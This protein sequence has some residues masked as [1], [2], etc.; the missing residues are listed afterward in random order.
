MIIIL[1]KPI[2][3]TKNVGP[4]C[5][6]DKK[7]IE[8]GQDIVMTGW[9][10]SNSF[11]NV[12]IKN[13]IVKPPFLYFLPS[14]KDEGRK[15]LLE[16]FKSIVR[17]FN[18]MIDD[19]FKVLDADETKKS[20]S[21]S[22]FKRMLK[23]MNIEL[24]DRIYLIKAYPSFLDWLLK[25]ADT[26][27]K[28]FENQTSFDKLDEALQK[29]IGIY[30]TSGPLLKEAKAKKVDSSICRHYGRDTSSKLCMLPVRGV[31]EGYTCQG[32][33][34]GPAAALID[35]QYVVVAITSSGFSPTPISCQCNCRDG[36]N[37]YEPSGYQKTQ[38]IMDWI[39]ITLKEY[40][41]LP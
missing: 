18:N 28:G 19:N 36:N 26:I 40:D 4:I 6:P 20:Q 17:D 7:E 11:D 34:G 5:L 33:S 9:G 16:K 14:S 37:D 35:N 24:S 30:Q 15:Y 25:N 23:K 41:A 27:S 8:I 39:K 21:L 1:E 10:V 13:N 12:L 3:F 22:Q 38:T 32:D 2:I 31:D 29:R